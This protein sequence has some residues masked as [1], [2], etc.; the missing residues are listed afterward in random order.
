[1]WIIAKKE[2]ENKQIWSV[3]QI[4]VDVCYTRL[5]IWILIH[6]QIAAETKPLSQRFCGNFVLLLFL[7]QQQFICRRSVCL[8]RQVW[9]RENLALLHNE[10]GMREGGGCSNESRIYGISRTPLTRASKWKKMPL[11]LPL[12][13][14]NESQIVLTLQWKLEWWSRKGYETK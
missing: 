7:F 5:Y 13:H 6:L 2:A 14:W 9:G 8:S 11:I 1:M 12:Q 10:F 4:C 3:V